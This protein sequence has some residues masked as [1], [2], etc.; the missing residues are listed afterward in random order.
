MRTTTGFVISNS[1]S[2]MRT[3][4]DIWKKLANVKR[5]ELLKSSGVTSMTAPDLSTEATLLASLDLVD[6]ASWGTQTDAL[7]RRFAGALAAAV[8]EAEPK[9]RVITLPS[10]TIRSKEDVKDWLSEAKTAIET[11]LED[12]PVIL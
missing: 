3:L 1:R 4:M 11:A 5:D 9:A 6:L 12:G 10:K 8:K 2:W 7:P